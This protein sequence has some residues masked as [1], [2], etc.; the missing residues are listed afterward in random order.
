MRW[1]IIEQT[2]YNAPDY[3]HTERAKVPG[4]WLVRTRMALHSN[5]DLGL[6]MVFV[7][8]PNHE[9]TV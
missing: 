7:P 2:M 5:Q 8:D 4:G 6:A 3:V 9:W 1:E